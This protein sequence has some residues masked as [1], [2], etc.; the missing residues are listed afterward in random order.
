MDDTCTNCDRDPGGG[1]RCRHCGAMQYRY[2]I[3]SNDWEESKIG[4]A[5]V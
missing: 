4:R 3:E 5:H 1:Y 2:A